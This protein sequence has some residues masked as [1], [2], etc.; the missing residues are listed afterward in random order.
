MPQQPEQQRP[1]QG[2]QE[3][4]QSQELPSSSKLAITP[5]Q[6]HN[7]SGGVDGFRGQAGYVGAWLFFLLMTGPIPLPKIYP[8]NLW[9]CYRGVRYRPAAL[10]LF[11]A[12]GGWGA[13][14]KQTQ[15]SPL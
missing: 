4:F 3:H 5:T 7:R 1:G 9:L 13:E 10:Q 11:V 15:Q 2:N 8:A 6:R 12:R 14:Y